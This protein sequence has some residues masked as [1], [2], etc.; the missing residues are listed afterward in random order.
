MIKPYN[1]ANKFL[2]ETSLDIVSNKLFAQGLVKKKMRNAI[3]EYEEAQGK[4]GLMNG[5]TDKDL[6]FKEDTNARKVEDVEV[7]TLQAVQSGVEHSAK[8]M[9]PEAETQEELNHLA[10]GYLNKLKGK[11][12]DM[13]RLPYRQVL[14]EVPLMG[15]PTMLLCQA[16]NDVR[17]KSI[18]FRDSSNLYSDDGNE[19]WTP[20][21]EDIL[22]VNDNLPIGTGFTVLPVQFVKKNNEWVVWH[23]LGTVTYADVQKWESD[24]EIKERLG[25]STIGCRI[26][27]LDK[28]SPQINNKLGEDDERVKNFI[29]SS[30]Q[31]VAQFCALHN[32][33]G[34][35]TNTVAPVAKIN[36]RRIKKKKKPLFEY[37]I[38]DIYERGMSVG[39]KGTGDGHK[40]RWHTVCGHP[41]FYKNKD[42][43]V[44][45]KPYSRGDK[46]FGAIDKTYRLRKEVSDATRDTN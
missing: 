37:K 5:W 3:V 45:I 34:I 20:L 11:F 22:E 31:I 2:K 33:K 40:N 13:I 10:G 36:K 23:Y 44:W 17:A 43:P 30:C 16:H 24:H 4:F 15:Y 21:W 38:L 25:I 1:Y 8:Y 41:R 27:P 9:L 18:L 39:T 28:N 35:K 19:S 14:L 42:K 7:R 29:L 26:V 12:G 32:I 6:S 46:S